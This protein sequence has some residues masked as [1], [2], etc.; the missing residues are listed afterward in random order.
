MKK[1]PIHQHHNIPWK[2]Q[3]QF[4]TSANSIVLPVTIRNL[5][6]KIYKFQNRETVETFWIWSVVRMRD[7]GIGGGGGSD[8]TGAGAVC[9]AISS[10][11]PFL[12]LFRFYPVLW[13]G[14][15]VWSVVTLFG[16][17]DEVR[18][19]GNLS[20]LRIQCILRCFAEKERIYQSI[21]W[22]LKAGFIHSNKFIIQKTFNKNKKLTFE[23]NTNLTL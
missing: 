14:E 13:N 22:K 7:S 16:E 6:F 15:Q 18:R 8:A 20:S 5:G 10:S 11:P 1:S 17:I 4:K 3:D 21:N 19:A 9:C 12:F 23:Y 2:F